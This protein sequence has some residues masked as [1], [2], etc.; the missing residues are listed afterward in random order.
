VRIANGREAG[1]ALGWKL[2][3]FLYHKKNLSNSTEL[4]LIEMK[5]QNDKKGYGL[6]KE[7]TSLNEPKRKRYNDLDLWQNSPHA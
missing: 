1:F 6:V 7:R 3:L 2:F 5:H 4:N